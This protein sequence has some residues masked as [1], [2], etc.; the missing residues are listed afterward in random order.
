[1]GEEVEQEDAISTQAAE[2]G[3]LGSLAG[4]RSEAEPQ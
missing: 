3:D 2:D 1:L 4:V